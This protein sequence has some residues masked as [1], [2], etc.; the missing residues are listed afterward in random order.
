LTWHPYAADPD[1]DCSDDPAAL[2]EF[3]L[4][5]TASGTLLRVIRA[6]FDRMFR[7]P[8]QGLLHE[9][10]R[11]G[12]AD[13][14]HPAP[15][16]NRSWRT[17]R[18]PPALGPR[19]SRLL[20][21]IASPPTPQHCILRP[22]RTL[23][24][25]HPMPSSPR[26]PTHVGQYLKDLA[27]NADDH[28]DAS[29]RRIDARFGFNRPRHIAAYR[30]F[31][32]GHH[33]ELSGRVLARPRLGGP[34][35]DDQWWENLLNTYRRFSGDDVPDVALQARFGHASAG[36]VTDAEG[37][38]RVSLPVDRLV[39]DSVPSETLWDNASIALADGSMMM[40]QP[41]MRVDAGAGFAVISDID[42]TVLQ[43]SIVEWKTAAQLAFLHNARTRKPLLGVARLYQALQSGTQPN[44]RHPIFYVSNSPWNLYDLLDDF[45]ELNGIPFGPLFLRKMG[46]H[47]EEVMG[48]GSGDHKLQRV[49]ELIQRFPTLRWVLLGDSGQ[50]DAE[51]YSAIAQEFGDRIIAIYIRDVDP[52]PDSP[53]DL[54]VK[55]FIEKVAGTRVPMLLVADSIAIAEHARGLGLID[56]SAIPEIATEVSR[57]AQRP[58]LGEATAK[59]VKSDVVDAVKGTAGAKPG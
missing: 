7:G 48:G 27:I 25:S 17:R 59:S 45:L 14:K 58:T 8:R 20:N 57:D 55:G 37:Y 36:T 24:R 56:A 28:L 41:V 52:A 33:V 10:R 23:T 44:L 46:L 18:Q 29:R 15:C 1:I 30:A 31:S 4:E 35:A 11:L 9:R 51:T 16:R 53:R 3:S 50:R 5:A 12:A 47:P 22:P 54:A 13:G 43:S 38:Y 40:P 32:D 21:H 19:S 6:R 26:W 34:Q 42:D 49:R 2:V 39:V